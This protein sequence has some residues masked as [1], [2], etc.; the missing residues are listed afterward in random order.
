MDTN[1]KY[2]NDT[3]VAHS[4]ISLIQR[5]DT[6]NKSLSKVE[7]D[8]LIELLKLYLEWLYLN[9]KSGWSLYKFSYLKLKEVYDLSIAN[10]DLNIISKCWSYIVGA[11]CIFK[12]RIEYINLK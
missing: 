10:A 2:W 12:D 1:F 4:F 8:E 7:Y 9:P 3:A 6:F 11:E 5:K